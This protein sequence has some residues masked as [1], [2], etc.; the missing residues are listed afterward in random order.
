MTEECDT[1]GETECCDYMCK[2]I[3]DCECQHYYVSLGK[4]KTLCQKIVNQAYYFDI[5]GLK[6]EVFQGGYGL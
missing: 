3:N 6:L 5:K 2:I 4:Y 1:G